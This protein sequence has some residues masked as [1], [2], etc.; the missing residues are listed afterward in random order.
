MTHKMKIGTHR[1]KD[2]GKKK[3]RLRY[4]THK[5]LRG[6]ARKVDA[7]LDKMDWKKMK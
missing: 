2:P 4:M 5:Y 1:L 6:L 7:S 3:I